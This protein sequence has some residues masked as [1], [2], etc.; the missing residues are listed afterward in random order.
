[1]RNSGL[2]K[3]IKHLILCGDTSSLREL[4]LPPFSKDHHLRDRQE[5]K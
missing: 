2:E 4:V 3:L 1:M 5:Q